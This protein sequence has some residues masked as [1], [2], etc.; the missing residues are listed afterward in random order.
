[1]AKPAANSGLLPSLLDRITDD[2]PVKQVLETQRRRIKQI[3][4]SLQ[5]G[6]ADQGGIE[7]E[8][9]LKRLKHGRAQFDFL[10]SAVSSLGDLRDCVK[11]DLDWLLNAR[12]YSPSEGLD[13]F[14]EVSHSVL[15]YGLPDLTGKTAT[16]LEIRQLERLLKQSIRDYEPRIIERTLKVQLMPDK[17]QMDNNALTFEIEGELWAEPVPIHMHLRTELQ[18]ESGNVSISDA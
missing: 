11:R 5:R 9:L 16:G 4:K 6:S 1:M 18:L 7:R 14:P 15:N 3:E 2:D 13:D 12:N 17:S 8:E 10:S